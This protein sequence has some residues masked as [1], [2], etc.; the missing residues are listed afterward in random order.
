MSERRRP[1]TRA[2]HPRLVLRISPF[3]VL[4]AARQVDPA[5]DEF[6]THAET[7]GR[8]LDALLAKVPGLEAEDLPVILD[9]RERPL[10]VVDLA[11]T[12]PTPPVFSPTVY[13]A[14]SGHPGCE[15]L[16]GEA[17][18]PY[19]AVVALLKAAGLSEGVTGIRIVTHP[20]FKA[21]A[22]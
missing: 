16:K 15:G 5:E 19:G 14:T 22:R 1:N 4:W 11:V 10:I 12:E 20:E 8:A 21:Y 18:D 13:A 7:P 2:K 9:L 3:G 17:A 6:P